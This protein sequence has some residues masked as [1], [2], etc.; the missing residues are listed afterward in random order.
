MSDPQGNVLSPHRHHYYR[1]RQQ[2]QW[3]WS[4]HQRNE[5]SDYGEGSKGK[6]RGLRAIH[7]KN[8]QADKRA[9]THTNTVTDSRPIHVD[10]CVWMLCPLRPCCLQRKGNR[11]RRSSGNCR[12]FL[13]QLLPSL[14]HKES[15]QQKQ[16]Q[17]QSQHNTLKN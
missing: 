8:K 10:I 16:E 7:P 4:Q 3:R 13:S 12:S 11:H 9:Y 17:L 6:V 14:L 1:R 15:P 5:S 2:S